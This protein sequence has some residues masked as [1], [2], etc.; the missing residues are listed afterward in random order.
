MSELNV[1]VPPTKKDFDEPHL[2]PSNRHQVKLHLSPEEAMEVVQKALKKAQSAG[3]WMVAIW[4]VEGNRLYLVDRT[5]W[6]F[7][8]GD[9]KA[10]SKLLYENMRA[11][12][13][14]PVNQPLPAAQ[15]QSS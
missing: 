9:Y 8:Q 14:L 4:C 5:T 1:N 11:E 12:G 10:A 7:P 15:L 6:E 13:T 2:Q 3:R